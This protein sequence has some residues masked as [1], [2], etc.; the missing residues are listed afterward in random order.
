MKTTIIDNKYT[1]LC[2]YGIKQDI[3]QVLISYI[4]GN[5]CQTCCDHFISIDRYNTNVRC[6]LEDRK[7]KIKEIL[8]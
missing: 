2:P 8:K 4:G 3:N 1:T 7:N 5:T 6:K